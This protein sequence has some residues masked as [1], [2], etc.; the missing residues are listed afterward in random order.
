MLSVQPMQ[1]AGIV[2][3]YVK[4]I[5]PKKR[6]TI[7]K[8]KLLHM[9]KENYI[10]EWVEYAKDLAK[11]E[12]ELKI[13]HWVKIS[14][15]YRDLQANTYTLYEIDLPRKLY[16]KYQWVIQWRKA[17]LVC[18][19]PKNN[20][21]VCCCFYD[22]RTG[23]KTGF[24]S[25]LSQLASRKAQITKVERKIQEYIKYNTYNNL[26][27]DKNTDENLLKVYQKLEQKKLN[28]GKM[29][30]AIQEAVQ[31]H[32]KENGITTNKTHLYSELSV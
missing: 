9:T 11:A 8:Q 6:I 10:N 12:K 20:V 18:Q 17:K 19:Y 22:K 14:F 1:L 16:E 31:K 25:M 28:A 7:R 3:E 5:L 21:Q 32:Q 29:Y 4:I 23:L 26:F 13:E 30:A 2:L 15:C 27:F 24:N